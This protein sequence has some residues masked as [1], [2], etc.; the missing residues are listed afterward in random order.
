MEK[1]YPTIGT[2]WRN[3]SKLGHRRLARQILTSLWW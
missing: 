3:W 2:S 1:C